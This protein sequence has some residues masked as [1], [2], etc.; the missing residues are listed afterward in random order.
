MEALIILCFCFGV[1]SLFDT[2]CSIELNI[3]RVSSWIVENYDAES[4][5]DIDI[6]LKCISKIV[7]KRWE[8]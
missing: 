1:A 4:Y 3:Y 8:H 7:R 5:F 2:D 6:Y